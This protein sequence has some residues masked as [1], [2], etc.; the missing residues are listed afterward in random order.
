MESV[1]QSF[2][3][4]LQA[5]FN[6]DLKRCVNASKLDALSNEKVFFVIGCVL[7]FLMISYSVFFTC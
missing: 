5:H 1:M 7:F 2:I 3:T 4:R 6:H